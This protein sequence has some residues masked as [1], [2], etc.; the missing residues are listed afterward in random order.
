MNKSRTWVMAN[1]YLAQ[2]GDILY[3]LEVKKREPDRFLLIAIF[4]ILYFLLERWVKE[5][6][7]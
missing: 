2:T 5:H 6:D 7:T 1:D 3:Q 4:R